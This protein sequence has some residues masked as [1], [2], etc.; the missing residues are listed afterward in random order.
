MPRLLALARC[1]VILQY[2]HVRSHFHR[3]PDSPGRLHE[4]DFLQGVDVPM[5]NESQQAPERHEI[6]FSGRVQGVG[7]RYT[8]C[9]FAQRCGLRGFVENLPDGRVFFVAEG[10][11]EMLEQF[12]QILNNEMGRFIRSTN[13]QKLPPSNEFPDFK[14]RR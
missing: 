8:A 13:V 11:P 14:I 9:Q 7:F 2:L 3:T 12:M 4:R 6:Y 10:T 5:E 1:L